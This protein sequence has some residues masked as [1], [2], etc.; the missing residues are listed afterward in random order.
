MRTTSSSAQAKK[1]GGGGGGGRGIGERG[2]LVR[3]SGYYV[4][5]TVD[6]QTPIASSYYDITGFVHRAYIISMPCTFPETSQGGVVAPATIAVS[7]ACR[8]SDIVL[9]DDALP[10]ACDAGNVP[11]TQSTMQ[12]LPT[13]AGGGIART[14]AYPAAPLRPSLSRGEYVEHDVFADDSGRY[15][16][17]AVA[18]G[19]LDKNNDDDNEISPA[20]AARIWRGCMRYQALS[21]GQLRV[22][23]G[24]WQGMGHAQACA[25]R[26]YATAWRLLQQNAQPAVHLCLVNIGTNPPDGLCLT[27]GA[28]TT[29]DDYEGNNGVVEPEFGTRLQCSLVLHGHQARLRFPAP[30]TMHS[31]S[32]STFIDEPFAGCAPASEIA[33]GYLVAVQRPLHHACLPSA[34]SPSAAVPCFCVQLLDILN[35]PEDIIADAGKNKLELQTTRSILKQYFQ[36]AWL[37]HAERDSPTPLSS[38]TSTSSALQWPAH[39]L[40]LP[41]GIVEDIRN[42][43]EHILM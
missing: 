4:Y 36:L 31:A 40:P 13:T 12:L 23:L 38:T 27:R 33:T 21:G 26:E 22:V 41:I 1:G 43:L 24:E 17:T 28:A 20:A 8:R 14:S 5:G 10:T 34:P 15:R 42:A 6:H 18:S 39:F 32:R 35:D 19:S 7:R 3:R 2:G 9:E 37:R 30:W 16:Q 29:G 25:W 11:R